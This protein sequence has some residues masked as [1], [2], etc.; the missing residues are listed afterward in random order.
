MKENELTTVQK[1]GKG[2]LLV[3]GAPVVMIGI[4]IAIYG[5]LFASIINLIRN[6]VR[7]LNPAGTVPADSAEVDLNPGMV[8]H[9]AR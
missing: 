7:L 1:V 3:I 4:L 6:L 9:M 8:P 2:I 5:T